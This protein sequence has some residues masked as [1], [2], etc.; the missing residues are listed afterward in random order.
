MPT[1]FISTNATSRR[2][3]L[4]LTA[5][6]MAAALSA[7]GC[8]APS[9]SSDDSESA[10]SELS[11]MYRQAGFE[12][13]GYLRV[14]NGAGNFC[15]TR[16]GSRVY[17]AACSYSFDQN[18]AAYKMPD[19]MY[20]AC[21]PDTLAPVYNYRTDRYNVSYDGYF[22]TCITQGF[23]SAYVSDHVL[24][25]E[26]PTR[27]FS[28]RFT[29]MNGLFNTLPNGHIMSGRSWEALRLRMDTFEVDFNRDKPNSN[30]TWSTPKFWEKI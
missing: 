17:G 26:R 16:G 13:A 11:S 10:D 2:F 23:S 27:G 3:N 12:F 19:G 30:Y 28:P 22:A 29:A 1:S 15:L 14:K 21:V 25:S 5:V 24:L 7:W 8:A 4:A 6:S 18:W 9:D 20:H